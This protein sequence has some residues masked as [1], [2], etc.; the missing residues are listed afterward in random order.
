[1]SGKYHAIHATAKDGGRLTFA[2][3]PLRDYPVLLADQATVAAG[4][5]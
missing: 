2:D 1:M 3:V 5:A 4:R